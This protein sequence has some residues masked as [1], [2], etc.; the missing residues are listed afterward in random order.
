[1]AKFFGNLIPP[2]VEVRLGSSGIPG[3]CCSTSSNS[4]N[5]ECCNSGGATASK[6]ID[7]VQ[8]NGTY[9]SNQNN[10]ASYSS[11]NGGGHG[12]NKTQRAGSGY[13]NTGNVVGSN[14]NVV[15][16]KQRSKQIRRENS[17]KHNQTFGTSV[18]DPI[19]NEDFDFEGNLALF[20]K[21]A[22][23]DSLEAGKKPDVVQNAVSAQKQ[24]KYRHDENVIVSEPAEMRQIEAQFDGSEDFVTDEGLIIPTVPIIVRSKIESC[25]QK[26]GLSLQRQLD[27]LARGATDLAILLLGGARR[28]TPTNRHQWPTI[29]VI[30]EKSDH[31][32]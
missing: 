26:C 28:L 31:F 20:D 18:D 17:V 29:A 23:W 7:I 9:Y 8:N 12:N 2:K 4:C 6:P 27:L 21:Q 5:A 22:I 32:R 16:S 30:C 19:L 13:V 3:G 24:K 1:M 10:A 14:G 11:G 15:R 25:A